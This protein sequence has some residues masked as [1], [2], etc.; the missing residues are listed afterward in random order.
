VQPLE[1]LGDL[2]ERKIFEQLLTVRC[3]VPLAFSPDLDDQF[4]RLARQQ[5]VVCF[6]LGLKAFACLH[7]I[8]LAQFV[9]VAIRD[10]AALCRYNL[11]F[12]L[13]YARLDAV[14]CTALPENSLPTFVVAVRSLHH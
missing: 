3:F 9:R 13:C 5:V 6:V 7:G 14:L 12:N 1:D 8:F 2:V 11:R 10:F 4:G